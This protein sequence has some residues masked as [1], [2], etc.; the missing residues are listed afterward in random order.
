[1]YGFSLHAGTV[2]EAHQRSKLERL[3]RYI[4][5]PPIVTKRLAL[6][7]QGR[8]IYRYKR[9][10]ALETGDHRHCRAPSSTAAIP[11]AGRGTSCR[12]SLRCTGC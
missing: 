11:E 10:V 9:H 3:C 4:T 12:R 6:D 2:C 1:M 8:V 7:S 5:R